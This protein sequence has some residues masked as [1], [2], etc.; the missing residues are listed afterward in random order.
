MYIVDL[1]TIVCGRYI[2]QVHGVINQLATEGHHTAGLQVPKRGRSPRLFVQH[3]EGL[4]TCG[5]M[6]H[7]L[8]GIFTYT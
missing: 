7:M 2:E 5:N 8:H 1:I 6:S 4:G 3:L